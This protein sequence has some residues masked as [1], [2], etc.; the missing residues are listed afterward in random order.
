MGYEFNTIS[1]LLGQVA[2]CHDKNKIKNN[3]QNNT[4]FFNISEVREISKKY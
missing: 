2:T 3:T 4:L 1:L